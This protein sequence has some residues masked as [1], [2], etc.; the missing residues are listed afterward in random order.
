[1]ADKID[2][3]R[4]SCARR[5]TDEINGYP[6]FTNLQDSAMATLFADVEHVD[7][8]RLHVERV[9]PDL[10][11]QLRA[12]GGVDRKRTIFAHKAIR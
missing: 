4:R 9:A 8:V 10:L 7:D 11:Q 1:M 12:G 3:V 5:A 2:S 6:R